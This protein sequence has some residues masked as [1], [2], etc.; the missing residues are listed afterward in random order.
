MPIWL[1]FIVGIVTA[2]VTYRLVPKINHQ[3]KI[4]ETRSNYL[5]ETTKNLNE[6]IIYLSHKV[7]YLDESLENNDYI[8]AEKNRDE[9][10]DS[11]IKLQWTLG[12]VRF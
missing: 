1:T 9:C 2:Y 5:S 10:L 7:R 6:E 3:Y 11:I 8:L 12:S 4:D